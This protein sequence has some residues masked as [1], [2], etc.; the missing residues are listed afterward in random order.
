MNKHKLKSSE[1]NKRIKHIIPHVKTAINFIEQTLEGPKDISFLPAYYAILNLM[2][3][4]VLLGPRHNELPSHRWHGASYDVHSKDSHNVLTEKI[5]IRQRGAIPLFYE[6][7]TGKKL[8]SK[9]IV[10]TMREIFPYVTGV[11][12]EYLLATGMRSNIY[13]LK[14][15]T[16]PRGGIKPRVLVRHHSDRLTKRDIKLLK[17]FRV[18]PSE[19]NL[20]LGDVMKNELNIVEDTRKQL[21][22]F[23]LYNLSDKTAYTP[24]CSKQLMLPQELPIAL[25]FFYMS[26]VVRYK[27]E[28]LHNIMDSKYWPFLAMA[29]KHSLYDFIM[30]FWSFM[31]QEN[32]IIKSDSQYIYPFV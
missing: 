20:F 16:F 10:L 21:N 3:I 26:M 11:G 22:T 24:I 13:A 19:K 5:E 1:A 8:P 7:I 29:R 9:N 15:D 31:H 23:L 12:H 6:T 4:Y 25:L 14:F 2:K 28:F 32:I 17:T 18:H 30:L 27:P